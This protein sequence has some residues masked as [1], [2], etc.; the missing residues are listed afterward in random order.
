[1]SVIVTL[2]AE[3][4]EGCREDLVTMLREFL[5]VTRHYKGFIRIS[6][7]FQRENNTVLF[8]EEWE[9]V[10]VYEAYLAW[11]GETGVM[12]RLGSVFTSAPTIRYFD[13]E[14]V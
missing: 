13:R 12:D 10:E 2:E 11:R 8:F 9:S 3:L 4:K 6:I 7:N 14:D 1:M 5:P